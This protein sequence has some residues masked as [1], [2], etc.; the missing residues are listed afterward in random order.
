MKKTRVIKLKLGKIQG[1]INEGI[2]T[3]KGI[4]FAE[5][6]VGDLRL[7]SPILKNS[8][9]GVLESFKYKPIAPQP[10]PYRRDFPP[11][12]QSEA[13]CLNLNIWTPGCDEKSR[14]V[15]IWIH[16]G[17]H[18][19]GSGRLMN[20]KSISRRGEIVLVSINYRLSMLG[21]PYLPGVPANIGD[22]NRKFPI[23]DSAN[24]IPL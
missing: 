7:R 2:S 6:P 3:F 10:P 18:R 12:P 14:P 23:G 20:G 8:W 11:P 5:P 9:D 16:G 19:A 4:P 15:M 17:G 24:G 22:L 21:Y 13:E 1:Y